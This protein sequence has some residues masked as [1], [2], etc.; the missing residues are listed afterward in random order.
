MAKSY[1]RRNFLKVSALSGG[2]MLISFNLLQLSAGAQPA[3]SEPFAPNAYIKISA[4]G[5]DC[6]HGP[7]S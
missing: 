6:A 5:S 1:S 4:D 3:D 7:Q 2:G